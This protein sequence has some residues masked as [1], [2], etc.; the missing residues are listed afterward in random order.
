[1]RFRQIEEDLEKLGQADR[2]RWL[3]IGVS[4]FV[5][6]LLEKVVIADTLAFF[7]DRGLA[8]YQ[9]LSTSGAWLAMIGYTFQLYFDFAGYSDMAIGLGYMFGLRF[10]STSIHRTRRSTHPTSGAAGTSRCHP[11]CA[12]TSTSLSE[13]IVTAS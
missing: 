11:V 4:F 9:L 10:R 7:V 8:H 2:V 1:M 12:T 5:V 6:G 13:E 3:G